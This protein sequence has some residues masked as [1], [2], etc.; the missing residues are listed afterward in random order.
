VKN[1]LLLHGAIGDKDQLEPLQKV[2]KENYNVYSFNFSGHGAEN[3]KQSFNIEQFTE[4]TLSF[5]SSKGLCDVSIFGYSM[6]GYVALYL[7]KHHPE[8]VNKI[9]TLGTKFKWAPDIAD[10]EVKM[11]NA[12]LIEAKI[13]AFAKALSVRHGAENW[14]TLLIKTAGM[15]VEMGEKNPLLLSDYQT[16]KTPCSLMLA[17]NDEMVTLKETIEVAEALPNSTFIT[18]PNS[19]HPIEKVDLEALLKEILETM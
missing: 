9:I 14:K 2:L 8:K 3:F 6:G 12:D 7:A 17:E 1:L 18:L 19:K 15:M 5:I 16:I 13:P 11:L 10:K 4:D